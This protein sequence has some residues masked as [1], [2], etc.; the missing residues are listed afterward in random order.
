MLCAKTTMALRRAAL[1]A[2]RR[3]LKHARIST[4]FLLR[5]DRKWST[6]MTDSRLGFSWRT[7]R[8]RSKQFRFVEYFIYILCICSVDTENCRCRLCP[9]YSMTKRVKPCSCQGGC[10]YNPGQRA[11]KCPCFKNGLSWKECKCK[12][13]INGNDTVRVAEL[14]IGQKLPQS[15]T[16]LLW[17]IPNFLDSLRP[18]IRLWLIGDSIYRTSLHSI[19]AL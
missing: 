12:N 3:K 18:G 19:S 10:A 2:K 9:N 5:Y 11:T 16:S 7:L 15:A 13:C 17:M 4:L 8:N 6:T 14:N 1:K